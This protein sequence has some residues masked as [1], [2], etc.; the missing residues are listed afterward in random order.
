MFRHIGIVVNDLEKMIWFYRD[1]LKMEITYDKTE[2]G[3]FLN[4]ILNSKKLSPRIVKLSVNNKTIVELLFFDRG[5]KTKKKTLLN[6]GYTHFAITVENVDSLYQNFIE[7]NLSIINKPAISQEN[8]V[9]VFFGC[10]PENN[11]IEFVEIL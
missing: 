8:N 11:L 6:N 4:H 5:K 7:N 10:D 3:V 2:K 1:F 9:K